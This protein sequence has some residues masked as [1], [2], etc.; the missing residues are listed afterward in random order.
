VLR[1]R[2][3]ECADDERGAVLVLGAFVLVMLLLI[4]GLVV[5]VALVRT[6][7]QQNKSAAD[8][9]VTAGL[10]NLELGGYPAPF[11][12]VCEALKF[13]QA[14][15]SEMAGLTGSIT[16][17]N[18]T[19]VT[20]D[21]CS[22]TST[23]WQHLCVP[24]T[25]SSWA[26]YSGT[27]QGGRITVEIWNGYDLTSDGGFNDE[28][29]GGVDDGESPLGGC[30][31]LAVIISES[32]QPSFARAAFGGM[33]G[34][35]I[36]TVGRI[37]QTWDVRAVVALLLLER[38]DCDSLT[39]NGTNAAVEVMGFGTHPGIIHS[40]SIGNGDDCNHQILNGAAVT[41]GGTPPY[42][43]PA[44]LADSAETGSPPATGQV[45][46]SALAGLIGAVP[47]RAATP[48]PSTVKGASNDPA[49][50]YTC[51]TGSSRKGR[52]N[53]DVLYRSR[54]KTLQ[55]DAAAKTALSSAPAGY[56][57]YNNCNAVPATVT[58][59][60]VWINCNQF[61]NAVTFS[62][63]VKEIIFTGSIS[64]SQGMTFVEPDFIYVGNGL[65][66][67]GG[68]L[69]VNTGSS[70]NCTDRFAADRSKTTK[71]VV[72]NNAFSTS[73]G[74]NLHLCGTMVLLGDSTG[75]S[76]NQPAIPSTDGVDPYDNAYDGIISLSGGGSL[77]WT[78]PNASSTPMEWNKT[79]SQP[80]LDDFEDLA[81][82]TEAS[83]SS[84]LSGGGTNNMVGVFF[85]PNAN[86]FNITG[87]GGQVI[88]SNAQFIVRKLKMGGNGVLK[89][90]PNPDDA[91]SVPYFSNFALVR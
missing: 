48:C 7:R 41:T 18:G 84:S 76:T 36:R 89:M 19:A 65:S 11:R 8:V 21:P 46:V 43:G 62:S 71:L 50:P 23:Y 29:P 45:S 17:G 32:E 14:N 6:D 85:L 24:N 10:R 86:P 90:R 35:R 81:F 28:P 52:I 38:N 73:G 67:T 55:A 66:R 57:S 88:E 5:D 47:S 40:D 34:S 25:P 12:G 39:F 91:I 69:N 49:I 63:T 37:T 77:D 72:A 79:A 78:A 26:K 4:A 74:A 30:D 87:N 15:S 42:N 31:N 3:R 61:N 27:A 54:M 9:A 2:I 82:W 68:T 56:T 60:K 51:V 75:A 80:Y 59:Q 58:A 70:T 44:I 13:L 83:D 53:V 64:G 22:T 33:M 20:G 16:W 1:A